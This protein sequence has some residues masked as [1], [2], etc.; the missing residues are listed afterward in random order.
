MN[1]IPWPRNVI[2]NVD[3][4]IVFQ[5]TSK[6]EV[7]AFY[8]LKIQNKYPQITFQHFAGNVLLKKTYVYDG[9][10]GKEEVEYRLVQI[11]PTLTPYYIVHVYF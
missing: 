10:N 3:I 5:F 1:S 2:P 8:R 11:L 4:S 7:N 9:R 6:T